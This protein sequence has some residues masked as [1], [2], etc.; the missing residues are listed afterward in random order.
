MAFRHLVTPVLLLFL[1]GSAWA[2]VCKG[3]KVPKAEREQY[4]AQATLSVA[5][6]QQAI[7]THLPWGQPT[8]PKLLPNREYIV[9]YTPTHRVAL[10]A[11]YQ[12]RAEDVVSATRRDAF[13]T[14]P[15]LSEQESA[16]CADYAGSGYDRGHIVPRDDMNRSP[17]AQANT[18]FLSNVSPQSP[19]LN[20][21]RGRCFLSRITPE[22]PPRDPSH[23]TRLQRSLGRSKTA[24]E[25]TSSPQGL[26]AGSSERI[27]DSAAQRFWR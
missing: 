15:R 21:G 1:A 26:P 20:R 7:Q 11:A 12:L 6:A 24:G 19:A 23:P 27:G 14:D 8:C 9:C 25:A 5:E 3:S 2:E 10:W 4:D 22:H 18:F 17:A 16:S 13:R